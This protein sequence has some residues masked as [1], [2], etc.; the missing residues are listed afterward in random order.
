MRVLQG[1]LSLVAVLMLVLLFAPS[2]ID[3]RAHQETIQKQILEKTGLETE[4]AGDL[5]VFFLPSPGIVL[6]DVRIKSSFGSGDLASFQALRANFSLLPLI[7]GEFLIR[8]VHLESPVVHMEIDSKG[9]G[10]WQTEKLEALFSKE[11]SSDQKNSGASKLKPSV[12][13]QKLSVQN[14]AFTLSRAGQKDFALSDMDFTLHGKSA[15]GPYEG[16]GSFDYAGKTLDWKLFVQE[17]TGAGAPLGLAVAASEKT[18]GL[19]LSYKGIV[20]LFAP[21][22]TQ[23]ELKLSLEKAVTF[24]KG[25]PLEGPLEMAGFL[26]A[27]TQ[28]I[29]YKEGVLKI[30]GDSFPVAFQAQK[31]GQNFIFSGGVQNIPGD[32]LFDLS[33]TMTGKALVLDVRAR[34][35]NVPYTLSSLAGK[36]VSFPLAGLWSKAD[37]AFKIEKKPEEIRIFDGAAA[38]DQSRFGFEGAYKKQDNAPRADISLNIS[39]DA[40]D[41]D[42]LS[43]KKAAGGGASNPALKKEEKADPV[44]AL[45][46]LRVPYDVSF[47]FGA[48][49][50]RLQ[51]RDIQGLRAKGKILENALR[52]DVVSVQNFEG[53]ALSAKAAIGDIQA[54][55]GLELSLSAKTADFQKL[56]KAL[57]IPDQKVMPQIKQ[58]EA[59]IDMS[60]RKDSLLMKGNIKALGGTAL[61]Q[62][63]LQNLLTDFEMKDFAFQMKHPNF[64]EFMQALGNRAGSGSDL[65]RPLDFYVD[66]ARAG[67]VYEI[68]NLKADIAG[69]AAEGNLSFDKSAP[70][71]Y[72]KGSLKCGDVFL[73][74]LLGGA[75]SRKR[76]NSPNN[77]PALQGAGSG[78][79]DPRWSRQAFDWGWAHKFNMD[80]SAAAKSIR[81]GPWNLKNPALEI[82]MKNGA[83]DIKKLDA[84]LYGGTLSASARLVSPKDPKNPLE[85]ASEVRLRNVAMENFLTGLAGHKLLRGEGM[86]NLDLNLK[87]AGISP[88]AFIHDLQGKGE[89]TGE[90]LVLNGI[91]F[92]AFAQALS[93]ETKPGD[94]LQSLWKGA[95]QGGST[96]FDRLDGE[97]VMTEGVVDLTKIALDGPQ[98]YVETTGKVNLPK[99][100][101][102]TKH[103]ITLKPPSTLPPFTM[104]ISGSLDNPGQSF[105]QGALQDYLQRK[106]SRKLEKILSDKLGIPGVSGAGKNAPA[107]EKGQEG[108]IKPEEAIRGILEGILQ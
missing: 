25:Y 98:A 70:I 13:L 43:K 83:L 66:I 29:H 63:T 33:G 16:N 38:M 45:Q 19:S 105:A 20:N 3:L 17:F 104:N 57:G 34:S 77:K 59:Q 42:E 65:A 1:L 92:V 67:D 101:M 87:G 18:L 51:G 106:I 35:H 6:E 97:F 30:K 7:K 15:K 108:T 56:A 40:L 72:I 14:A 100:S 53:A 46:A 79:D 8:S 88:A 94:S 39:V 95:S 49:K 31:Q 60:G 54:L 23:G 80:L 103:E 5:E 73:D 55:S 78:G 69:M 96:A 10:N 41:F 4:L 48:Q 102:A 21:Y 11:E 22:E 85:V 68:T 91:D 89:I 28:E 81:Q 90:K 44:A 62:G 47:D 50:L 9:R 71:P 37:V 36:E 64:S 82:S 86:L 75:Q 93:A 24:S 27:S 58:A 2:F 52:L 12:F 74:S 26:T 61:W 107:Q 84:G 99:W 76:Q 32:A